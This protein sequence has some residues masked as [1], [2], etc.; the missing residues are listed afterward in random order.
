M[1]AFVLGVGVVWNLDHVRRIYRSVDNGRWN[2]EWSNGQSREVL[3]DQV[4]TILLAMVSG[5]GAQQRP[6]EREL[7]NGGLSD[8]TSAA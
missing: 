1:A 7:R 5:D 8:M 4:S 3:P 6:T 2:I